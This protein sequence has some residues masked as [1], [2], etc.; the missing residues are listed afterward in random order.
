M[1]QHEM[2]A[3]VPSSPEG[4]G[5]HADEGQGRGQGDPRGEHR[6]DGEHEDLEVHLDA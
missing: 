6:A 1:A 3:R 4:L 2:L 5:D